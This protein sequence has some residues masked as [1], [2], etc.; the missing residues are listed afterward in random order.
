MHLSIEAIYLGAFLNC[1][2]LQV[3]FSSTEDWH[4][5]SSVSD[6][7]DFTKT[8]RFQ[9]NISYG[10][11]QF[12]GYNY[13]TKSAMTIDVKTQFM[14]TSGAYILQA[15]GTVTTKFLNELGSDLRKKTS[16]IYIL[17][18][19]NAKF[20]NDEIPV[21]C[22]FKC[23]GMQE[24]HL[25]SSIKRIYSDAFNNT[26]IKKLYYHGSLEQ[27]LNTSFYQNW[28]TSDHELYINNELLTSL[29]VPNEILKVPSYAFSYC[30]SIT[31]LDTNNAKV[32][33]NGSFMRAKNL[34]TVI[35]KEPLQFIGS[36]C[37]F[38]DSGLASLQYWSSRIFKWKAYAIA[39]EKVRFYIQSYEFEKN[40]SLFTNSESNGTFFER[41]IIE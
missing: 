1:T 13:L 9:E 5:Y 11:N 28:I 24:L 41:L 18:L 35:I 2:Q 23:R 3:Y 29:T 14:P 16:L 33:N 4:Y 19:S 39:A 36:S 10:S 26:E 6:S 21:S 38:D 37:F 25:P 31:Y 27:Y 34:N 22:F 15:N 7:V 32:L 12:K 20:E 30:S 8:K 17:D 40:V